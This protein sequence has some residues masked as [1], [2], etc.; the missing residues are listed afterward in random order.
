MH[1]LTK[2][3]LQEDI[4]AVL[5]ALLSGARAIL[6]QNM[7]G[8]WLQGSLATGD[9]D[10]HSDIDFVI[11]VE[12]DLKKVEIEALQQFH[13]RLYRYPSPWAVH[14]EG[15]YFPKHI[16]RDYRQ[17]GSK[18]WYLDHGSQEL[19]R[20]NHDNTVVVKWILRERG[21]TLD[22]P[23][24]STM[25]NPIPTEA[26][27][28]DTYR[29]FM[30][31]GKEIFE[32]PEIISNHFYQT[33]A[34]LSFCRMLQAL[35]EGRIGSKLAGA[36]WVKANWDEEWHDLIDRA[37]LGRPDPGA[38]V[39]RPADADDLRRTLAFINEVM[40]AATE[41]MRDFGLDAAIEDVPQ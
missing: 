25:I 17:S 24:P 19:T 4:K 32:N 36:N 7:I 27:R 22:G 34:V 38:S 37:W 8:A 41:L 3:W 26:L 18:I 23:V 40:G 31:W 28:V 16:L 15:S 2:P 14:L 12:A 39:R 11:G 29:T 10:E 5:D 9:F 13:P 33:F 20:S 30:D 21:V 35:K 1:N 6:G